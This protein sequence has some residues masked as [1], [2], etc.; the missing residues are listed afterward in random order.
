MTASQPA[1]L[2]VKR[3]FDASAERVFDKTCRGLSFSVHVSAPRVLGERRAATRE[4]HHEA[5]MDR[6]E[7][8]VAI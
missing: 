7:Q 8:P 1:I 6:E 3:R 4:P 5:T 2:Q